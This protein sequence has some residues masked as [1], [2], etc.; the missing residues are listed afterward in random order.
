MSGNTGEKNLSKALKEA[1]R[2]S[3]AGFGVHAELKA[4]EVFKAVEEE[5]NHQLTCQ[6]LLS[7]PSFP[8]F[9]LDFLRKNP[10]STL[11]YTMVPMVRYVYQEERGSPDTQ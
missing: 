3:A 2:V 7:S 8:Q 9:S 4:G 11:A 1:R 5:I 10:G 6:Q